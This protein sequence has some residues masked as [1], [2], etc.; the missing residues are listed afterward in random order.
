[1]N[2]GDNFTFQ[3]LVAHAVHERPPRSQPLAEKVVQSQAHI[4]S[5]Y[6]FLSNDPAPMAQRAPL[7]VELVLLNCDPGVVPTFVAFRPPRHDR[8]L[9]DFLV[10]ITNGV[11]N[12]VAVLAL[13]AFAAE[14]EP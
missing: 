13:L 5:L 4:S 8:P 7:N 2:K 10:C 14:L 1:M 9:G 6:Y 12:F 11:C 3:S